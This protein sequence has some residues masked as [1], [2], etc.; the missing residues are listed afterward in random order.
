MNGSILFLHFIMLIVKSM[1]R[2][3]SLFHYSQE[4]DEYFRLLTHVL[5]A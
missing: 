5:D 3:R 1:Y 2:I 4:Q